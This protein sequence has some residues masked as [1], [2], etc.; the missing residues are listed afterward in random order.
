MEKTLS[1]LPCI[2][3]HQAQLVSSCHLSLILNQSPD[4]ALNLNSNPHKSH[5]SLSLF[6]F[7]CTPL[8]LTALAGTA[9]RLVTNIDTTRRSSL[10]L[11][12]V[13]QTLLDIGSEA[14]KGLVDVDVALG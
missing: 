3:G 13:D 10:V 12:G 8:S 1:W 6:L 4:I 5:F 14:V 9:F 2:C 11:L 7:I